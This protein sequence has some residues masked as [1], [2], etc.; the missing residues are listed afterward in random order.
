[1]PSCP[2]QASI[3]TLL[4]RVGISA[5]PISS[6]EE[7]R[8]SASSMFVAIFEAMFQVWHVCSRSASLEAAH[9]YTLRSLRVSQPVAGVCH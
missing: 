3:N 8:K 5:K 2:V 7:L 6:F 4:D 1:M 9:I